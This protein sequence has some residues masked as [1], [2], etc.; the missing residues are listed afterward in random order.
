[1][2]TR[3]EAG[4]SGAAYQNRTDD[5]LITRGCG[6]YLPGSRGSEG[7]MD[8]RVLAMPRPAGAGWEQVWAISVGRA[9]SGVRPQPLCVACRSPLGEVARGIRRSSARPPSP[10]SMPALLGLGLNSVA[11]PLRSR[12][13]RCGGRTARPQAAKPRGRSDRPPPA[14]QIVVARLGVRP[15]DRS[16]AVGCGP[17]NTAPYKYIG[18]D[19][20]SLSV[21]MTRVL[22]GISDGFGMAVRK[23]AAIIRISWAIGHT[24]PVW[25]RRKSEP[26]GR[27]VGENPTGDTGWVIRASNSGGRGCTPGQAGPE[28]L[29]EDAKSLAAVGDPRFVAPSRQVGSVP[30]PVSERWCF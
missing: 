22:N 25:R 1:M 7:G 28:W 10:S 8:Y 23:W 20:W 26:G 21:V 11:I 18:F 6:A 30:I 4:F 24:S 13:P 2:T 3:Q 15:V 29:A 12:P 19:S 27:F 9:P 5:L 16:R 17:C 14:C